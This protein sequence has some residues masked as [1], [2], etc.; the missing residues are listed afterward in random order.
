MRKLTNTT[1]HRQFGI[2]DTEPA[3]QM[4]HL[5]AP[6]F[7]ATSGSICFLKS[8]IQSPKKQ[9]FLELGFWDWKKKR[10]SCGNEQPLF[11]YPLIPVC[12]RDWTQGLVYAKQVLWA[13][14]STLV[15]GFSI[16]GWW[17]QTCWSSRRKELWRQCEWMHSTGDS[18]VDQNVSMPRTCWGAGKRKSKEG[19]LCA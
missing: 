12:D 3:L 8:L 18:L 19:I 17:L 4:V 10:F 15:W 1:M 5:L 13:T 16:T 6:H 11:E 14:S 9:W 2:K 7:S